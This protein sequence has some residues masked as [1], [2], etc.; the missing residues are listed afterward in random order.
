M[1]RPLL[2]LLISTTAFGADRSLTATWEAVKQLPDG[3]SQKAYL[4]LKEGP[5][6]IRG[7][8]RAGQL[9]YTI[10]NSTGG[11]NGFHLDAVFNY[12][13]RHYQTVYEG[14]LVGSELQ[15]KVRKRPD[16]PPVDMTAHRV[17]AGTGALPAKIPP[18]ALHE[19]PANGLAKTPPMGW[20]SWNYFADKVDDRAVRAMAEAMV[21][22]GMKNAG[23]RYINIDDTWQGER[24]ASGHIQANRKFPDM[25][26]LVDYV[27]SKGLKIGIYSSPGPTTC[28]GYEG[29]YGHEREDAATYAAWGFDFLKYDWCSA[30]LIYRDEEMRAVYQKMADAL[31]ATG[32]PILYSL[33][34]YGRDRVWEWGPKVGGNSWRTTWDIEDS[35]AVMSKIGFSQSRIA[36]WAGPGHW[37]DPD[38]LEVGNGGMSETEYKTHMSL[39]A[40]LAAPLLAGNDLRTASPKTLAILMNKDVIAID[41]DPEG[42]AASR[43]GK[44]GSVEVWTRPLQGG[45][46]AVAFFNRGDSPAQIDVSWTEAGLTKQP[47]QARDLWTHQTVPVTDASYS[48]KIPAH[49]VNILRVKP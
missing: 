26:G 2:C 43:V 5:N 7:T 11:P 29:S 17:R 48:V 34:Q 24:D 25:K 38:M 44:H 23:Y 42:K 32:R 13:D 22:N 19:V 14:K 39:W 36:Q 12:A 45:D 3:T 4:N 9:L 27:H 31:R 6:G 41:Q 18:P 20:N 28:G 46:R 21:A 33:C 16:S 37:N 30:R 8:I 47:A 15:L 1:L 10:T 35:W 40:M 49:G